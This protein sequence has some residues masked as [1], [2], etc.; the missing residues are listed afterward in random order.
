MS[1][2]DEVKAK[3]E[4][5]AAKGDL[6]KLLAEAT[7]ALA[8][9][10][11]NLALAATDE[12]KLWHS[13]YANVFANPEFADLK[14]CSSLFSFLEEADRIHELFFGREESLNPF[15]VFFGEELNWPELSPIGIISTHF[16][17]AGRKGALGVVGPIR[18]SY[19]TIIPTL[20]YFSNMIEEIAR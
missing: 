17:A 12:G 20:K 3:E 18:L 10:T 6:D 9:R 7:H 11:R 14:T 1:L 4:V 16:T 5:G 2:A 13:G 19:G 8:Q 15:D